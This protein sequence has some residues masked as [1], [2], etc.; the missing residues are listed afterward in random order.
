MAERKG[1]W[2]QTYTGR[3][4]WPMDPRPEEICIE[5]IAHALSH[6]C[7]YVGHCVRFESVAEH[8][9]LLYKAVPPELKK[10]AL[11]H[12]A[13]E[14]YIVDL[15]RPIKPFIRA[16]KYLERDVA[17]AI[18]TKFGVPNIY[19]KELAEYDT[20]ILLDEQQQNMAPPPM[21]W[22]MQDMEP[23]GVKLEFWSPQVA[24][25]MFLAAFREAFA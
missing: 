16:Y 15:P 2:M 14:A 20:R 21:P 4:F 6:I 23:L 8:S 11:L 24:E 10:P 19:P 3:A 17:E 5:D 1:D 7:R 12:D 13:P 25:I 18:Q 9:V 22:G